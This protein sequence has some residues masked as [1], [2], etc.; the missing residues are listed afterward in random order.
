MPERNDLV[1]IGNAIL[2]ILCRC[3]DG[4]LTKL[5]CIKGHMNRVA[6]AESL[7]KVASTLRPVAEVSGGKAANVAVGIASLGGRS[8]F[9]GRVADDE[10]GR[11]FRHDIVG[12]GVNYKTA[13][14]RGPDKKTSRSLILVTPDGQRTMNTY[15]GC[16]VELDGAIDAHD[17]ETAK[18]VLLEGYLFESPACAQAVRR[19]VSLC[20]G[21][22]QK[23][24]L[25]LPDAMS[26]ERARE[27]LRAL[28]ASGIHIV[29]GNE[30]E[31]EALYQVGTLQD[32]V[33]QVGATVPI[34]VVTCGAR[35]SLVVMGKS[36]HSIAPEKVRNVVDLT[37]AGD[38]FAAGF[39]FGISRGLSSDNSARL[40][41]FAA[42]EIIG[43]F[44]A[45]PE[46]NLGNLARVRGLIH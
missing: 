31:F 17:I 29:I 10:C 7:A 16:S 2:D 20:R 9:I 36:V 12:A 34:G 5:G 35:G 30:K 3:D 11:I 46:I 33:R 14:A 13:P 32:A 15:L 4:F 44:G 28:V 42:A 41:S 25:A 22:Y 24:A 8:T 1:A 26:V 18:I 37:G 27:E 40:A 23:I 38:L 6:T 39:L 43:Q 45:R 19:A 21:G